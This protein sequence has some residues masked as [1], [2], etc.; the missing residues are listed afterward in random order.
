MRVH[1]IPFSRSSLNIFIS[2]STSVLFSYLCPPSC[3]ALHHCPFCLRKT[4]K[5]RRWK[6]QKRTSQVP[7]TATSPREKLKLFWQQKRELPVNTGKVSSHNQCQYSY[8]VLLQFILQ[9]T[10]KIAAYWLFIVILQRNTLQKS[11][12]S[13]ANVWAKSTLFS[14]GIS[15]A[16]MQG[17]GREWSFTHI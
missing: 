7:A 15:P 3:T 5:S 10:Y 6:A 13:E 9:I 8:L 14:T 2:L 1:S 11:A 17:S 4:A 12:D 16:A